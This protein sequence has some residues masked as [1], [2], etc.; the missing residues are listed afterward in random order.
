MNDQN[1]RHL[2]IA[3]D[4]IKSYKDKVFDFPNFVKR[5]NEIIKNFKDAQ[6]SWL[7]TADDLWFNLEEINAVTLDESSSKNLDSYKTQID[8]IIVKLEDHLDHFSQKE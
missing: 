8:E 5:L 7:N 3:K 2:K 6:E 4:A 1:I